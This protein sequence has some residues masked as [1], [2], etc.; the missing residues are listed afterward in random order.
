[1]ST[2]S[3]VPPLSYFATLSERSR[4]NLERAHCGVISVSPL[5]RFKPRCR[6]K[7]WRSL[8]PTGI[9]FLCAGGLDGVQE[10]HKWFI[11]VWER[12][13]VLSCTEVLVVGVTSGREREELPGL[14]T[15]GVSFFVSGVGVLLF[16]SPEMVPAFPFYRC[17]GS[18]RLQLCA[19]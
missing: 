6:C 19:T 9:A 14:K 2:P 12:S 16:S 18:T 13:L 8:A 11:L 7:N 10:E 5:S 1:M 4:Y 15:R 3:F 17:K